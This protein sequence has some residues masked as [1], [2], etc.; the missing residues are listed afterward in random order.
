MERIWCSYHSTCGAP[1]LPFEI[2]QKLDNKD[3]MDS[4]CNLLPSCKKIRCNKLLCKEKK[5]SEI[6]H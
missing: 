6:V 5:K 3:M 2:V 4:S 1:V